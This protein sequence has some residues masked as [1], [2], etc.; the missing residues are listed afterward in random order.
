MILMDPPHYDMIF[1]GFVSQYY[2]YESWKN[3]GR[4]SKRLYALRRD[5]II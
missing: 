2:S 5:D 4:W 1:Y 3:F